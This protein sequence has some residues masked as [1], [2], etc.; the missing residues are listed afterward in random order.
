MSAPPHAFILAGGRGTR[1]WP[2]STHERPKQLLDFTGEGSL[3]ALTV[4]RLSP[5]VPPERQ[6]ILTASDLADAVREAVP[7]VPPEQIIAEPVGR[8]TAPAVG[9][10]AAILRERGEDPA[11][12][13][14][15]SD[16]LIRPG[17]AFRE[18]LGRAMDLAASEACLLTFGIRPTRPETGYGYI[19]AGDPFPEWPGIRRVRA[20]IEKPPADEATGF[21]ASGR[22]SWNS[23][24]FCWRASTVL[25]G[26]AQ[27]APDVHA[28]VTQIATEGVPGTKGFLSAL[29]GR[30]ANAPSISIDYA[31][32]EK[33]DNTLVVDAEFEWNDL[34]HWVAMRELWP[35]AGSGN[36][37]RGDVLAIDAA[38]NIVYGP[39]RLT[40]LIGV[41]GHVVVSTDDVTLVCPAERAQDVKIALG[42]LMDPGAEHQT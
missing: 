10:A 39:D 21:V 3:L 1:F 42:K 16:H 32:M 29:E 18:C 2:L 34:G 22:H 25:D 24:I 23:G 30:F 38:D 33:A 37:A 28:V 31:L 6:W 40:A 35:D 27:H 15:P 7:Q 12:C 41:S 13:V 5:L 20:F 9:L 4:S 36:A 11:F 26:L 19:E 17:E 14:L 8:N